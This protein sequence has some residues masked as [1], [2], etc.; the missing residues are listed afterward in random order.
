M[1][2]NGKGSKPRPFSIPFHEYDKNHTN[3]FPPKVRERYNGNRDELI[4]FEEYLKEL[5]S[6]M[7]FEIY[8]ELSGN[9]KDDKATWS[10]IKL[11]R[12]S[13]LNGEY[14]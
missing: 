9:W 5:N 3:I 6:G 1:S 4:F 10:A 12:E 2:T 14:D 11:T 7:F 8:P 13:Q